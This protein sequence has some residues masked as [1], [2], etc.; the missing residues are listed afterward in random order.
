VRYEL[1]FT[2]NVEAVHEKPNPLQ[3]SVPPGGQQAQGDLSNTSKYLTEQCK[4]D[5]DRL[6][7]EVSSNRT[8]GYGHQ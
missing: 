8:K 1:L 6:F 2:Q 7:S 3:G 4:E 5:R